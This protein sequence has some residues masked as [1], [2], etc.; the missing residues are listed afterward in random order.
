MGNVVETMLFK[1]N[2]ETNPVEMGTPLLSIPLETIDGEH[3]SVRDLCE[4]KK[5]VVF[6]NVASK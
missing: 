3:I 5:L 4:G 2:D 6:A 1:E